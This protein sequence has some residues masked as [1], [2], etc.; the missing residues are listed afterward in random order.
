M[1]E[2]V[3]FSVR[4]LFGLGS[5]GSQGGSSSDKFKQFLRDEIVG[6]GIPLIFIDNEEK[7]IT[8]LGD[9]DI[10]SVVDQ[11][12]ESLHIYVREYDSSRDY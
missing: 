2:K 1:D 9:Y 10:D 6:N 12:N 5:K 7:T 4:S 3:L 8:Q 11:C